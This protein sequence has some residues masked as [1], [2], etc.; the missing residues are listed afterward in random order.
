MSL[1][2]YEV[3]WREGCVRSVTPLN[4]GKVRLTVECNTLKTAFTIEYEG[5]Q[6][7]WERDWIKFRG[8]VRVNPGLRKNPPR[9]GEPYEEN[10]AYY[11][12]PM[13]GDPKSHWWFFALQDHE[14]KVIGPVDMM[15]KMTGAMNM[16]R[17]HMESW[18][19]NNSLD[20]FVETEQAV[21]DALQLIHHWRLNLQAREEELGVPVTT[22]DI[23]L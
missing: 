16:M 8:N 9:I 10:L 13:N 2:T 18:Q 21:T 14:V 4:K 12:D 6:R 11:H 15:E 17:R 5:K 20:S 7:I 3:P 23:N 22:I 1:V 19:Y